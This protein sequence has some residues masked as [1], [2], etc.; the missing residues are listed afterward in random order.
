MSSFVENILKLVTGSIV[1]QGVIVITTPVITRLYT[2]EVFGV[3]ALFTSVISI[4]ALLSS[5]RYDL[6]IMLPKNDGHAANLLGLSVCFIILVSAVTALILLLTGNFIETYINSPDFNN[7]LWL[8]PI[9]IFAA[10]IFNPFKLWSS[11]F[12]N[13]GSISIAQV[14]AAL[15]SQGSKLAAGFAGYSSSGALIFSYLLGLFVSPLFIGSQI[16][17]K[18]KHIFQSQVTW[19]KMFFGLKHYRDFPLYSTWSTLLNSASTHLPTIILA[20]YFSPAVVGYYALGK[21]VL[22]IPISLIGGAVAQVFYQK[23]CDTRSRSESLKPVVEKVFNR[24]VSLGMLPICM[25][26]V[27]SKDVFVIAFGEQWVQAGVYVQILAL[28]IFFQFITSP[29][30]TLFFVLEKQGVGLVFNILL[31]G[32]RVA[33]LIIGGLT[34][35]IIFT[36]YLFMLTGVT[37]YGLLSIYLITQV[38][39]SLRS[40]LFTLV[41]YLL[42]SIPFM[43]LIVLAKEIWGTQEVGILVMSF[44]L[45]LVYYLFI[46]TQDTELRKKSL[47]MLKRFN[48]LVI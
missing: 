21:A 41:K 10:G 28:W 13:F 8:I 11:R 3:A 14:M 9:G 31:L 7:F 46:L 5:F 43:A 44:F 17:K 48:F 45:L 4:I 30:S 1:A 19:D 15:T 12:K 35:N 16:W 24:L 38:G 47:A 42:N 22:K 20:V 2:P 25:L 33:S 34:G 40:S 18:Q 39:I 36:L 29:I 6:A 23:A 37:C 27:I 26:I 32:T